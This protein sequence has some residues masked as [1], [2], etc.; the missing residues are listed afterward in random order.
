MNRFQRPLRQIKHTNIHLMG[1]S[2][3]KERKEDKNNLQKWAEFII[4][5][6]YIKI[7]NKI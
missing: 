7:Y 1:V 4:I 5:L 3:G 2:E 6:Y